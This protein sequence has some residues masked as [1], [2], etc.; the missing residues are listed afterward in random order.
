M[1]VFTFPLPAATDPARVDAF[2][3]ARGYVLQDGSS[4][5]ADETVSCNVDRDPSADLIAAYTDAPTA[6]QQIVLTAIAYLKN[7]YVP[8]V[9]A[10]A[11]ASR[12]PEQRALLAI[13]VILKAQLT[14]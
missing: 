11:P 10:I 8:T 14:P 4:I 6:Q 5:S 3:R 2:L 9:Q 1:P 12:T 7:T 13:C